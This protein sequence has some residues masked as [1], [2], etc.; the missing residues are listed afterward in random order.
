M[1]KKIL[2][3]SLVLASSAMA[4]IEDYSINKKLNLNP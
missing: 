3:F 1:V 2:I 4:P